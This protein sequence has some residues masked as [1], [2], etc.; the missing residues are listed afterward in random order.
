MVGGSRLGHRG[1]REP[2]GLCTRAPAR[3]SV[4]RRTCC[5][6]R[7]G[8]EQ[9][10]RAVGLIG[11]WNRPGPFGVAYGTPIMLVLADVARFLPVPSWRAAAPTWPK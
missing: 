2:C 6:S 4:E 11:A 8:S 3:A 10:G 1:A 5:S 7:C 9:G